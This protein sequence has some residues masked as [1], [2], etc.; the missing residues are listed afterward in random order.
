MQPVH[1]TDEREY[2]GRPLLDV[3]RELQN[4]GLDFV[5]S[6]A[7]V[8]EELRVT[9][10]PSRPEPRAIL[11]EILPPLGLKAESGPAGSILILPIGPTGA[12]KGRVLSVAGGRPIAGATVQLPDTGHS[13][14]SEAD[15]SFE[16]Q[17]LPVGAHEVVVEALGFWTATFDR[18]RV[19]SRAE[20]ELAV[21]LRAQPAFVTEVVVTP[22]RHS[23]VR[24][25]QAS[26]HT[27]THEEAVLAPTIGGDISR[28]VEL[29]PGVAAADNSAA[30]NV[31]GSIAQDVSMV[32]D[33]LELYDPFH[34]QSFQSPFSLIDSNVVDRID[35]FGGGFTADL[36]DRHGGFVDI[37]T[38]VPEDLR[39]GELELG[40]LNSRFSYRAPTS[41]GNGSWLVSA[42]GWYPDSVRD[43]TE[44]GS[45]EQL[46]PKFGDIYAKASFNAGRRHI[47]STHGLFSYDRLTFTETG[48]DFNE[49]VDALTRNGYGWLRLLS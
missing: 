34:L 26:R 27:V 22:N 15:G 12:L 47:L 46:N 9:V 39:H 42:R 5:F 6:S 3:L 23:V 1:A 33:G 13:A 24:Q 14:V 36:G 28:V 10:E 4:E 16:I 32:L 21:E 11:E 17:A 19:T 20:V 41:N 37:S 2:R 49:D 43:S 8:G 29:L 48:E 38:L 45:G 30:F 35:F 7:V 18:V 44:L 31:R 25:E 40:T